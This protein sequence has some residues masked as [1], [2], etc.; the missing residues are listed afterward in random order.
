[1]PT[2]VSLKQFMIVL[3][4]A[5][6]DQINYDCSV[7]LENLATYFCLQMKTEV[8]KTNLDQAEN[9]VQNI[10]RYV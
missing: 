3:Q 2:D 10:C 1:M 4:S 9:P 8:L 5:L 6:S 7:S